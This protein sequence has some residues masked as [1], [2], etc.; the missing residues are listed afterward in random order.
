VGLS[1]AA[2][3][4]G[5]GRTTSLGLSL[6]LG[7]ANMRLG[8]WWKS[9]FGANR[10][11]KLARVA[12]ALFPTQTYLFY[13][14]TAHFHGDHRPWHY[15]SDGGH[16]ENTAAYELLRPER[17]VDVIVVSDNGCDPDYEFADLANLIR[18][19]RIDFG[20]EVERISNVGGDKGLAKIFGT[21]TDFRDLKQ[22]VGSK[23]ALLFRVTYPSAADTNK[24]EKERV[25]GPDS[26]M[27]ATAVARG[28]VKS[29]WLIVLKPRLIETASAD[30]I[31]YQR[32]HNEFP[33][34]PT[35]DQFFD[36]AQWES[37]RRLGLETG[38][39]VFGIHGEA[40][41]RLVRPETSSPAGMRAS[42]SGLVPDEFIL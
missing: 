7:L 35:F 37:Y 24:D 26:D 4:T 40:L 21:E 5:L 39:L 25:Q 10:S 29:R 36:E 3:T 42:R 38:T 31:Q 27:S 13:E 28:G 32:R 1:G 11:S 18:L 8:T 2:F 9:G 15:L 16:F 12:L 41:N 6:L 22:G 14:F 19:A 30:V 17:N 23:C 20:A 33:Q 34:Q